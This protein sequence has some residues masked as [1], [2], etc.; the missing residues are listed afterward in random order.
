MA[1][2]TPLTDSQVEA[3]LSRFDAG[4]LVACEGV[5]AGTENSTFFVTT[6][7][8]SLV[9]TLFEQGEHEELPFF[10]DLLDYLDEH[11][12]PVPGPL[13]D[14]DGIALHSLA[15]KPALLFPRLPGKHPKA[16]NLAQ[17]RALGDALGRMHKVSRRFPGHRPN[18]RDLHWL[19]PMHHKVL[20]YLSPEDQA[21]MKDEVEIYQGFFA[22][23]PE[24][25]QGAIHG[26]LFRDNTL[27]EG[28]ELGGIIDFYNGCTGDLLFDLAIVIND[29]ATGPDG[30]LAPDRYEALLAAYQARRPL[31]PAEREAWPMMLR[32]TALRYWLSRL[33]VVYVDP[34]A[35]DLTPH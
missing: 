10:V 35:H 2:F 28:D 25:P 31:E 3:F 6:D 21:L 30:R 17:C 27:F 11:R 24:L 23:G 14:R 20:V 9:L 1:V 8:R 34:P 5:P 13:H 19:L 7:R 29:W 33:L 26:D 22:G 4:S 32:M 16:P 15:G 12:L 18:P